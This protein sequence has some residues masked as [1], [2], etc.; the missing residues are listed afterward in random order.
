MHINV[1]IFN[2]Y[3]YKKWQKMMMFLILG[4]EKTSIAEEEKVAGLR[5]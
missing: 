4:Q 1:G 3:N 2:A 5:N